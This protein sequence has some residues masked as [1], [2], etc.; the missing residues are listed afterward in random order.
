MDDV[1]WLDERE[2][3]VWRAFLA[4]GRAVDVAVD[5]QLT[6]EGLSTAEYAV[7]ASLSEAPEDAVRARELGREIGWDSSR[8]AH[9]LRRMEKRGLLTRGQC[10]DDARGTMVH[11]TADGRA[12]LTRAAPGHVR[13]V[14][15]HFVD[16]L[17]PEE[18]TALAAVF[19]RLSAARD[20]AA[21][22]RPAG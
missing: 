13:T 7:L 2:E 6:A 3:R 1:A 8:L 20:D 16:L 11:L 14:R 15:A 12:A 19:E 21:G 17:G 5:Q 18:Q 9:Q 22:D 4:L 10:P